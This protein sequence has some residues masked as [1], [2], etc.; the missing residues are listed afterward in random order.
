[1]QKNMLMKKKKKIESDI[2]LIAFDIDQNINFLQNKKK[3][4][5]FYK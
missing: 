1:M 4:S 5:K 3:F 2:I